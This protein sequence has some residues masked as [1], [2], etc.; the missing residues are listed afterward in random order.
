MNYYLFATSFLLVVT[1]FWEFLVSG[2]S[3]VVSF[4]F[5]LDLCCV[6]SFEQLNIVIHFLVSSG[7]RT[8]VSV[9]AAFCLNHSV[10]YV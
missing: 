5:G 8:R 9:V 2:E 10:T 6:F 3:L 1:L 4:Q 7:K